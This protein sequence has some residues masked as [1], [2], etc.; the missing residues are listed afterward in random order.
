M[1]KFI[2]SI[3]IAMSAAVTLNVSAADDIVIVPSAISDNT[4]YNLGVSA[5]FAGVSSDM[6]VIAGGANFPDTPAAEGGR[7]V[8][9]NDIFVLQ[10]STWHHPAQLPE[11]IAYG[12]SATVGND[13]IMIGGADADGSRTAVYRLSAV[14]ADSVT[15]TPM[16]SLPFPLQEAAAAVIDKSIYLFGGLSDGTACSDVLMLDTDNPNGKWTAVAKLAEPL[17]QPIASASAGMIYF[18]GGYNKQLNRS[19]FKG[20]QFNPNTNQIKE[21]ATHPQ[22]GTFTGATATTVA[23]GEIVIIGGVD[24]RTFDN[25]LKLPADKVK[26]YLSQ[27][28]ADYKFQ[29]SV[30][31]YMPDY[32]YWFYSI[33]DDRLARA[34]AMA[35]TTNAG[36]YLI[37]GEIKPGIRTPQIL[38]LPRYR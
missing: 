31:Y 3:L 12:A 26:D 28:V 15:I 5:M 7:K 17:A 32:N 18:W 36:T 8:Y 14:T 4:A 33:S 1:H 23:H 29:H 19:S 27:P 22:G 20:Y 13:L 37:G 24:R 2:H 30:W 25:A 38:L 11:S 6:L 9:Y 21:I 16:P 35:V 34:G 10:D